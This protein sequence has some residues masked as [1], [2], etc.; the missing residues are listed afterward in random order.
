MVLLAQAYQ[1]DSVERGNG[2]VKPHMVLAQVY[3]RGEYHSLSQVAGSDRKT[4]ELCL[5][6]GAL[7]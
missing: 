3:Q 1:R 2:F 6:M 4:C 7:P 5:S